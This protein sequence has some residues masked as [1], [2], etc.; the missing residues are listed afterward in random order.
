[1]EY[2]L[3]L[4]VVTPQHHLI[5]LDRIQWWAIGI[6]DD[7]LFSNQLDTLA[8]RR[9]TMPMHRAKPSQCINVSSQLYVGSHCTFYCVYHR[10]CSDELFG[11][12]LAAKFHNL[13]FSI[14]FLFLT[15]PLWNQLH[16]GLFSNGYE[17]GAFKKKAYSFSKDR[18][19]NC[20]TFD[21]EHVHRWW[22]T[23]SIR[24]G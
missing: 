14:H 2:C 19:R 20:K 6:I 8:S 22:W 23:L 5:P 24:W 12:L 15:N 1:M 18:Q 9:Y 17:L 3:Y 21:I 4:R 16:A 11:L 7:Q 13:A 10:M